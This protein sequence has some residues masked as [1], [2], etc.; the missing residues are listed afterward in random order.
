MEL[1]KLLGLENPTLDELEKT[2]A[3]LQAIVDAASKKLIDLAAEDRSQAINRIRGTDTGAEERQAAKVKAEGERADA[4]AVLSTT[5]RKIS[6][7][8]AQIAR[9]AEAK[10]WKEV[11]GHLER[12][13]AAMAEIQKLNDKIVGLYETVME[14]Y[15]QA[16]SAAP[17]KPVERPSL[18]SGHMPGQVSVAIL[19]DLHAKIGHPLAVLRIEPGHLHSY[20]MTMRPNGLVSYL[21]PTDDLILNAENVAGETVGEAVPAEPVGE[22][23]A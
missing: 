4:A 11:R 22:E 5:Q 2:A 21:Q 13:R 20:E 1:K 18:T 3:L 17:R 7:L 9:D 23:A 19:A 8:R 16:T 14:A 10:A 12:R 6:D 15:R